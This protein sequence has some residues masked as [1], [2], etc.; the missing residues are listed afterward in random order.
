ML[1]EVC[2]SLGEWLGRH[3]CSCDGCPSVSWQIFGRKLLSRKSYQ[4]RNCLRSMIV[5]G[6]CMLRMRIWK[7]THELMVSQTDL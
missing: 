5:K 4:L 6:E 1:L 2:G 7:Y 3:F